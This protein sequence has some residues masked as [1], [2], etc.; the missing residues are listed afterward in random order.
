M[1][2]PGTFLQFFALDSCCS[3]AKH[4][5]NILGRILGQKTRYKTPPWVIFIKGLTTPDQ[6]QNWPSSRYVLQPGTRQSPA[7]CL[8]AARH[9]SSNKN[10]K[11]ENLF[12]NNLNLLPI[13]DERKKMRLEDFSA[14]NLGT[15]NFIFCNKISGLL[16]FFR[17]AVRLRTSGASKN[18]DCSGFFLSATKLF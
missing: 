12:K 16:L 10:H 13:S 2:H 5:R 7:V 8:W 18:P 17:L 3:K 15:K 6:I 11:N 14:N 1:T 9:A 4:C